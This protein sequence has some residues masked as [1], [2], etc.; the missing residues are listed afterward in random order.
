ML[1]ERHIDWGN[2]SDQE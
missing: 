1:K 2:S